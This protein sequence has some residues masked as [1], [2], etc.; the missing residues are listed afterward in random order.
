MSFWEDLTGETAADASRAAAANPK[1]KQQDAIAKLMGYGDEY[2]GKF[3]TLARGYDPYV[4]TGY[5]AN[6]ALN[7]LISDPSSVRSLPGYEFAQ[8]EGIQAIDRSAVS[9]G[10]LNSGRQEK[11]LLRFG[12]GLADKTYG[13]QLARLMGLNQQ[14]MGATGAQIGT[15]AEGLRGQLGT[16]TSA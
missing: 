14:G 4:K 10:M 7:R 15:T 11:D 12:T 2:A 1:K 13:D 9:R 16:R 3:D 5:S 8:G 6:N